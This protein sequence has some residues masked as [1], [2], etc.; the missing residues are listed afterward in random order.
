[1]KM[2]FSLGFAG[3]ACLLIAAGAVAAL[4]AGAGPQA[5][6]GN[7][8]A[9]IRAEVDLVRLLASVLDANGR[10]M[11]DLPREAFTLYEEGKPQRIELFE[12]ETNQPLDMALMID[13]SLSTFKELAFEREAAAHF[14]RQVVR[15]GD[16]LSIFQVSDTVD[17]LS[18]FSADVSR[19][20]A[21]V[22]AVQPGSATALYDAVYLA[23]QSLT[24][25]PSGRRRVIVLLTDA[26]ETASTT[27]FEN[28]RRA[29]IQSEAL[30][31]TILIRPIKSESGRNTAGE[32]ALINIADNTGGVMYTAD[33][34]AQLDEIF[35]RVDRE[36]RTQYRIGYYPN[37]RPAP[38]SFRRIELKLDCKPEIAACNVPAGASAGDSSSPRK[39][40]E[41][42]VR[43]RK[44]YFTPEE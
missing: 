3:L 41:F 18:D 43:F 15:P 12:A 32:H 16:R 13:S 4:Y 1:M 14:I 20:Q 11:A 38:R 9:R 39:A 26:G 7:Q 33:E 42:Q 2:R 10:P 8:E 21:A 40:G 35:D 44:G 37:P 23:S 22:R 34:V 17:Q 28:A 27:T 5:P 19:L 36:L 25:R 24:R 29:A 31:Y 6:K 30:L